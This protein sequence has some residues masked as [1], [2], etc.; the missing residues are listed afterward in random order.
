MS[1]AVRVHTSSPSP[2]TRAQPRVVSSTAAELENCSSRLGKPAVP[3]LR[4]FTQT[5]DESDA[6]S[7]PQSDQACYGVFC[8]NMLSL[9][10]CLP[11]LADT[12]RVR[13]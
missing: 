1:T 5:E 11:L 12:I 4:H 10:S 8:V 9:P 2:A 6:N 13:F 7:T 3:D